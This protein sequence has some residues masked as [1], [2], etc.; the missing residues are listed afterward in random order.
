MK[1]L[2]VFSMLCLMAFVMNAQ[3][4]VDLGLPSGTLWKSA[5]E[6]E[7]FYTYDEATSKFGNKLPSR[8]QWEEL[9]ALCTWTWTGKGYKVT[10]D[11]GNSIVLPAAGWRSSEGRWFYVGS[12]GSYWSSTYKNRI[13]FCVL[14][15]EKGRVGVSTDSGES[16]C[17]VRLVQNK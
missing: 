15:F 14:L 6:K 12:H 9:I 7:Y 2:L 11:N 4:F 10:G 8:D 16:G 17:S 1:K 3:V 5:N 13:G